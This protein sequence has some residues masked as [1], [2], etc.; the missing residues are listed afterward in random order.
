[1][2]RNTQVI[3]VGLLA[4][5]LLIGMYLVG[6]GILS[7]TEKP[8]EL[9]SG[10]LST[11]YPLSYHYNAY[12]SKNEIEIYNN[13]E[14]NIKSIWIGDSKEY[15]AYRN[16]SL[17]TGNKNRFNGPFITNSFKY[18]ISA[19]P[20]SSHKIAI[21]IDG[22]SKYYIISVQPSTDGTGVSMVGV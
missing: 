20:G 19:L 17:M 10:G 1:M 6:M 11:E 8:E 9:S 14:W 2:S 21:E 3:F 15:A 18:I 16:N 7:T 5:A 13:A 12:S 22:K 4:G